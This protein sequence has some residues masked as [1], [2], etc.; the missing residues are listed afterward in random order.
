[1]TGLQAGTALPL[2]QAGLM[3]ACQQLGVQAVF[4]D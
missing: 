1:M 4:S 2:T 3:N